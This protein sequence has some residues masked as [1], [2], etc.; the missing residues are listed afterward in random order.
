MKIINKEVVKTSSTLIDG[1]NFEI[2][3]VMTSSLNTEIKMMRSRGINGD[4][5]FKTIKH[6]E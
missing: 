3:D 1:D 5:I 2:D 4:K 6:K